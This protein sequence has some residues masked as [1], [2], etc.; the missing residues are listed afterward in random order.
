VNLQI[1]TAPKKSFEMPKKSFE[2]AK[3]SFEMANQRKFSSL[4]EITPEKKRSPIVK[5]MSMGPTLLKFGL[6]INLSP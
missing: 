1:K 6:K 4:N 2:I 3:K 5:S